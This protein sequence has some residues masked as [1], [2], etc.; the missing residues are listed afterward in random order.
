MR[1]RIYYANDV[2]QSFRRLGCRD[3]VWWRQTEENAFR[4]PIGALGIARFVAP[5]LPTVTDFPPDRLL[6]R[7]RQSWSLGPSTQIAQ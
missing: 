6:A 4:R 1:S 2:D 7:M 5:R 3:A